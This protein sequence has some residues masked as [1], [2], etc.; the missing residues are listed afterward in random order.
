MATKTKADKSRPDDA[1]G[2][3]LA[4]APQETSFAADA[5]VVDAVESVALEVVQPVAPAPEIA[6]SI[7]A[8]LAVI[9]EAVESVTEAFST[10]LHVDSA[11][12]SK[13]SIELWSEN[14]AAFLDLAE[15]IGKAKSFEDVLDIQSRFAAARLEAFLRQSQELM[16]LARRMATLSVAPLCGAQKAA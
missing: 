11:D 4:A 8:P 1:G 13:K 9:E 2:E 16:E 5:P 12:W 10:S 7:S 15:E 14:A 6:D 3:T